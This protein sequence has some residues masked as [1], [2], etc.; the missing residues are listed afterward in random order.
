M[1]VCRSSRS[2]TTSN[3][4][5]SC[6]M[7]ACERTWSTS[8]PRAPT[9]P[10]ASAS[11]A[12][13]SRG[14]T[15]TTATTRRSSTTCSTGART[16]LRLAASAQAVPARTDDAARD[17]NVRRRRHGRV[18]EFATRSQTEEA[19]LRG[20]RARW[21]MVPRLM[22]FDTE[23]Q[24]FASPGYGCISVNFCGFTGLGKHWGNLGDLEWAARCRM[25]SRTPPSGPSSR[26]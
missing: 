15:R 8:W 17:P 24:L 11:A 14:S 7:R 20:Q 26:D 16:A 3:H 9:A 13:S 19:A 12:T 10:S 18:R 25:T 5:L 6:L 22:G 2:L 21:A 23:H 1:T 4:V